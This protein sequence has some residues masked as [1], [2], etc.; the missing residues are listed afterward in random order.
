MGESNL[1]HIVYP[2]PQASITSISI[3]SPLNKNDNLF[4]P[5]LF[6]FIQKLNFFPLLLRIYGIAIT[7]TFY[8]SLFLLEESRKG[9]DKKVERFFTM[10]A[11]KNLIIEISKGSKAF[12][13]IF[14]NSSQSFYYSYYLIRFNEFT[15]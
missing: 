1:N 11:R 13:S 4:K 8:L 5:Y 10:L 7:L 12:I 9:K 3:N 14:L 2:G 6:F 15:L